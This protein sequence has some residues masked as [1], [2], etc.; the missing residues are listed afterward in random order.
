MPRPPPAARA[1]SDPDPA[2]TKL[3]DG[4]ARDAEQRVAYVADLD[5][6]SPHDETRAREAHGAPNHS[7]ADE[8]PAGR[9]Y[10]GC[11]LAFGPGAF[12]GY[13]LCPAL[14][15]RM[16]RSTSPDD[17]RGQ[18]V[19]IGYKE[20]RDP[21]S[22]VRGRSELGRGALRPA[23]TVCSRTPD[24]RPQVPYS[25]AHRQGAPATYLP[26]A[27]ADAQPPESRSGRARLWIPPAA[28]LR[29]PY[30]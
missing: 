22:G 28:D 29:V 12:H 6:E 17:S 13:L 26:A 24:P 30:Q 3:G 2:L 10:G 16:R 14:V 5:Q 25:S 8:V 1:L 15:D 21:G 20:Q 7:R 23:V 11:S 19:F 4:L 27:L 18:R 9:A